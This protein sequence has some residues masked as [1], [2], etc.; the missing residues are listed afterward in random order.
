MKRRSFVKVLAAL[1]VAPK[2]IATSLTAPKCITSDFILSADHT[3]HYVGS[4]ECTY[5][6]LELHRF[7]HDLADEDPRT[8]NPHLNILEPAPSLRHTDTYIEL[9]DGW[10][11]TDQTADHL[12]DGT[13]KTKDGIWMY[14]TTIPQKKLKI[15]LTLF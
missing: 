12:T 9:V 8:G 14:C 7:L 1:F 2:A 15:L 13:L 4:S 5:S 11:I 3:I 10:S 6:V